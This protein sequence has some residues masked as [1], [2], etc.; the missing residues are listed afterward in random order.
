MKKTAATLAK[1]ACLALAY[2]VAA[3]FGLFF[4]VESKQVAILCRRQELH[5]PV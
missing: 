2:L 1:I 4:T 3:R 5:S